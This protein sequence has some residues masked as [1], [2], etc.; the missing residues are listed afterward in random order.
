MKSAVDQLI[1]RCLESSLKAVRVLV[2]AAVHNTKLAVG[3]REVVNAG[4]NCIDSPGVLEGSGI[5]VK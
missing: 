3:S 2:I 1:T 5:N 4:C